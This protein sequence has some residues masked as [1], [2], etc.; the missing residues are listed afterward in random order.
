MGMFND[1]PQMPGWDFWGMKFGQG[2]KPASV[3][4]GLLILCHPSRSLLLRMVRSRVW[5]HFKMKQAK[6]SQEKKES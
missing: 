3:P 4:R 1:G 5:E 6:L 2:W